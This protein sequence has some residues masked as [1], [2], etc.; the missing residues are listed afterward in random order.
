M[1]GDYMDSI[2]WY[3][4]LQ[5]H[6]GPA[7]SAAARQLSE[8]LTMRRRLLSDLPVLRAMLSNKPIPGTTMSPITTQ[9]GHSAGVW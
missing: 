5:R 8:L 2:R 9:G 6:L 3:R 4:A 1:L 7:A